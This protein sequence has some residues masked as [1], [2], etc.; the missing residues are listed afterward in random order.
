MDV[1]KDGTA[2][3][4]RARSGARAGGH[5]QQPLAEEPHLGHAALARN[6]EKLEAPLAQIEQ[7]REPE[8]SA[9]LLCHRVSR[10]RLAQP[11]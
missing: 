6:L 3:C 7:G 5:L 4:R 2:R 10:S 9:D 1:V 11:P 8:S